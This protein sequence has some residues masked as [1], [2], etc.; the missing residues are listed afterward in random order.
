MEGAKNLGIVI[1]VIS[2][3]SPQIAQWG[4][5]TT[6]QLPPYHADCKVVV[7]FCGDQ[8]GPQLVDRHD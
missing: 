7:I 3:A 1:V 6:L 4:A 2:E 5:P 8:E